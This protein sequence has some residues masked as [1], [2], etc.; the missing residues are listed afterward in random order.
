MQRGEAVQPGKA[1][2]TGFSLDELR[3]VTDIPQRLIVPVRKHS[4]ARV[5][6]PPDNKTASP[7]QS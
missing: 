4:Q 5:L 2:I 7:P 6:L 1:L 3:V